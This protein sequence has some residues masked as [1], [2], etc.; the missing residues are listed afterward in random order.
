MGSSNRRDPP[1]AGNRWRQNVG[2]S[3]LTFGPTLGPSGRP[4]LFGQAVHLGLLALFRLMES[5]DLMVQVGIH[6]VLLSWF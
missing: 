3:G 2:G 1:E 6:E 5:E 4:G